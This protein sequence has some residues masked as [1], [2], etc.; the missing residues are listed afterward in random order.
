MGLRNVEGPEHF[1]SAIESSEGK[2]DSGLGCHRHAPN[3]KFG[4]FLS[5]GGDWKVDLT[6]SESPSDVLEPLQMPRIND[7][8]V[9]RIQQHEVGI[10]ASKVPMSRQRQG[11][12]LSEDPISP[13]FLKAGLKEE[14]VFLG[15]VG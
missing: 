2:D 15:T 11:F 8:W 13:V 14:L 1:L 5:G 9:G 10:V 12:S 6:G 3:I 4:I 7:L